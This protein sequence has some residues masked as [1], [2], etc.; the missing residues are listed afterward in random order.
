VSGS[1]TDLSRSVY[2]L[3]MGSVLRWAAVVGTASLLACSSI[4]DECTGACAAGGGAGAADLPSDQNCGEVE[5][6]LASRPDDPC[7]FDLGS[8]PTTDGRTSLAKI[9]V[10][11]DGAVLPHGADA[12]SG[13]DYTDETMTSIV[14]RGPVC[15]ALRAGTIVQL[16]VAFPC[17]PV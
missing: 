11:V 1:P 4:G 10:A 6:P 3:Q 15:D 5:H 9:R 12:D 13:W 16:T 14:V 17:F 8:A 7:T 2:A